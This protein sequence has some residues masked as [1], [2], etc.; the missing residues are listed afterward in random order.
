MKLERIY[1]TQCGAD[2]DMDIKGRKAVFCPFCGSQFVIDDGEKTITKNINI[3]KRYTNDAEVEKQW[4]KDRENERQHKEYKW[5]MIGIVLFLVFDMGLMAF[6]ALHE[7]HIEQK[8][9]E[10]GMIQIGQSAED[11]EG[12]KYQGVVEQLETLG[13]TN[14]NT[15]DMDDSGLFVR[16]DTIDN[17]TIDGN[18]SFY[19]TDYFNPDSNIVITYH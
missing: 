16:N 8:K 4:R 1:C 5:T 14:I 13:F 15:V 3:H 11:F 17:I 6:M 19:S 10:A 9:V 18:S 7:D 2:I 12:K